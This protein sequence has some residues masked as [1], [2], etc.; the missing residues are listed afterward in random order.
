MCDLENEW[1]FYC[2]GCKKDVD[3]RVMLSGKANA[4][5]SV[6]AS[7]DVRCAECDSPIYVGGE[8]R[9]RVEG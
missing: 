3:A 6:V 9:F 2:S 4:S 5:H 7:V 8:A 1:R